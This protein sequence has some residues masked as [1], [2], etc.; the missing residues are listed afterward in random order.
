MAFTTR[1][2]SLDVPDE[3]HDSVVLTFMNPYGTSFGHTINVVG[4]RA[5]GDAGTAT[6]FADAQAAKLQSELRDCRMI[7][8]FVF[9]SGTR[10]V[11][12]S[13]YGW[14]NGEA[15]VLQC[16]AYLHSGDRMW[17]LTFTSNEAGY[18]ELRNRVP[19]FLARF[20]PLRH[21]AS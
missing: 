18:P 5:A 20:Q 13:E 9:E 19:D 6:A 2:Y 17:T 7:N 21:L 15:D 14:K 3:W 16:Q 12:I 1:L 10:K 11:P 4:E 8:R